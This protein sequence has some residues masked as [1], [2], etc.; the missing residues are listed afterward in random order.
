M[1]F[2]KWVK[3]IQTASYNGARTVLNHYMFYITMALLS[4][5]LK[6]R[7]YYTS[8]TIVSENRNTKLKSLPSAFETSFVIEK[9]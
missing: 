6:K 3:S 7:D 2:I 9:S 8:D 5:Y 4:S 1:N